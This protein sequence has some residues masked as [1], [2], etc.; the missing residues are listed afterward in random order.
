MKKITGLLVI[1]TLLA[2]LL[3]LVILYQGREEQLLYEEAEKRTEERQ[4]ASSAAIA[5]SPAALVP[6]FP[7]HL[8]YSEYQLADRY[9]LAE[10]GGIP[11]RTAPDAASAVSKTMQRNEKL[12]CMETVTVE[13]GEDVPA[14][15]YRVVWNDADTPDTRTEGYIEAS[16]VT[17]RS[18]RFAEAEKAVALAQRYSE[19]GSLTY[20]D[21]F[22]ERNGLAP[23][24]KGN[25]EDACGN[26]RGQSAP[27]YPDPADLSEFTYLPDGTLV[28]YLSE[29]DS[30][31]RVEV[32]RTG[33]VFYVPRRYIPT[34]QAVT[35]LSK[36]IVIDRDNQN[37]LVYEKI[38]G[39]WTLISRTLAT[40]GKV[41][42]YSA[43]TPD[44]YFF[45][46][47]KRHQF[48]YY[49]DG[50]TV[51][52]GYAPYAIRFTDSAYIHGVPVD[53]QYNSAGAKIVPGKR[54]YSATIGTI[55]LSH[56][57]VRNYTSHAKFLYDWFTP[58]ETIV[59]VL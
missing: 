44:G 49:K 56:K 37:E 47:E 53:Y 32:L 11:I 24:Y 57:C 35:T 42:T 50:T 54:E 18:F 17:L 29:R 52:Q 31:V 12:D 58:G 16:L 46:A 7:V 43:P 3:F 33:D 34:T 21:N 15:W 36:A 10:T 30:Y 6:A 22:K 1:L 40:T 41:G 20:I 45:A 9:I 48:L 19:I 8:K 55:P 38:E 39:V 25:S 51:F 28:R 27:A 5:S 4:T 2:V 13:T 14:Y 59:I 23:L 26:R